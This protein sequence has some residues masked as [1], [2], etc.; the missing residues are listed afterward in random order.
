MDTRLLCHSNHPSP[1]RTVQPC[2]WHR[3]QYRA[4][5]CKTIWLI[6][7]DLSILSFMSRLSKNRCNILG[8]LWGTFLEPLTKQRPARRFDSAT[9]LQGL[10]LTI[11]ILNPIHRPSACAKISPEI[12]THTWPY[13]LA[14]SGSHTGFVG[15]P[16]IWH[17]LQ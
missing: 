8:V 9:Y 11:F 14:P 4:G 3:A 2:Q 15:F 16:P 5:R 6:I 10:M 17:S 12:T 1:A 13:P 7:M